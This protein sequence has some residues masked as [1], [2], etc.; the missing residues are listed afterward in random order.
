[1]HLASVLYILQNTLVS[2]TI[3]K[4]NE[5]TNLEISFDKLPFYFYI[6]LMDNVQ[7]SPFSCIAIFSVPSSLKITREF[8]ILEKR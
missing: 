6:K 4:L 8:F 7:V 5:C 1:M 2:A 3:D